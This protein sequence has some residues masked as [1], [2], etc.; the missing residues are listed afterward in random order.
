MI[1]ESARKLNSELTR[2]LFE[3]GQRWGYQVETE[4]RISGGRLDVVWKQSVPMSPFALPIVGFEIESS[5]RTRKHIK[6]DYLNLVD[7]GVSLGVIV[8]A[9]DTLKDE[10]L[11][12]FAE[13]FAE[14]PGPSIVVW[15]TAD[16]IAL[17]EVNP[18][19]GRVLPVPSLIA[20]GVRERRAV[21]A[22]KRGSK[23]DALATWLNSQSAETVPARFEQIE[24]VL[25]FSLPMSARD[26]SAWWSSGSV[27]GRAI[28]AAGWR[29]T[30]VNLTGRTIL[31][32]RSS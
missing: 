26:H 20:D 27:A 25:G 10:S 19:E 4:Y 7:A 3:A 28:A 29:A 11:R 14:R 6:G 23:Y 16:V 15:S 31:F 18:Q 5:W 17:S 8:L 22:G 9:G 13:T 12:R 24:E 21:A 32:V 1:S 30:Q 2:L